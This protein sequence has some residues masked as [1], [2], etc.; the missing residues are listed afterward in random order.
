V[1]IAIAHIVGAVLTTIVFGFVVLA[2]SGW[3]TARNQRHR[4]EEL[5]I[6]LGVSVNDL[7]REDLAPKLFEIASQRFTNERFGNRLSDFCAIVRAVWDG[8]GTLLQIVLLIAVL[9]STF[10]GN[11]SDAPTAWTIPVAAVVFWVTG[12]AFA[13]LCK[14][15]TGR[16]PGEAKEGRKELAR[17]LNGVAPGPKTL[18]AQS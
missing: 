15:L 7:G 16:Y 4:L 18:G 13:L 11:L 3:E 6:G 10:T 1:L 5:A 12:T 14:L 17:Y 9:G 2:I 8:L